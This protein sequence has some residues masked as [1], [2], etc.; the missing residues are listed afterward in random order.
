MLRRS[1]YYVV[2]ISRIN[3]DAF[4]DYQVK[5]E[6]PEWKFQQ[7][8]QRRGYYPEISIGAFDGNSLVGFVLNGLRSWNGNTTVYDLG[9]AVL[10]DYRRQG[11]TKEMLHSVHKLLKEKQVE[12]YLLEVITSNESAFRLYP[13]QVE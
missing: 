4:F 13:N 3:V 8:L 10:P 12:Q 9:T 5:I 1:V 6:L 2:C 11:I 7:M